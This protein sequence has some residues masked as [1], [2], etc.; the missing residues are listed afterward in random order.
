MVK[1][2]EL[3]F[4]IYFYFE[5]VELP[6]QLGKSLKAFFFFLWAL[7]YYWSFMKF[8]FTGIWIVQD[9]KLSLFYIKMCI[10]L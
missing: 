8:I 6:L 10:V 1:A 3:A 5:D 7:V 9:I 2:K 4:W